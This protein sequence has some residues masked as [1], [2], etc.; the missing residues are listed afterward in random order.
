MD[1]RKEESRLARRNKQQRLVNVDA[2]IVYPIDGDG[3]SNDGKQQYK[4][5]R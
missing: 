5:T 1:C 2:S 3:D 4:E